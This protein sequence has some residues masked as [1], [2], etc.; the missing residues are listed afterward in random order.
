MLFYRSNRKY[1]GLLETIHKSI[2]VSLQK[3]N[4]PGITFTYPSFGK[5]VTFFTIAGILLRD[6]KGYGNINGTSTVLTKVSKN[7]IRF[8]YSRNYPLV[9]QYKI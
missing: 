4:K 8:T 1:I 5:N 7:C 2:K 9:K 3:K 6:K